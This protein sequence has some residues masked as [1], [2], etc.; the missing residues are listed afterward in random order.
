M[1]ET[2][3]HFF[4]Y[5]NLRIKFSSYVFSF[6]SLSTKT[7]VGGGGFLDWTLSLSYLDLK[8]QYR[9]K[10]QVLQILSSKDMLYVDGT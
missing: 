9:K 7:F 5:E 4:S 2:D 8:T 6:W 3:S 1:N 10:S